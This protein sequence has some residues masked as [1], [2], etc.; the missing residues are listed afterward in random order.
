MMSQMRVLLRVKTLK[1]KENFRAV[2]RKRQEV[3]EAAKSV[4]AANARVEASRST[5]PSRE[6]AIYDEIIG[7]VVDLSAI[8]ETKAK[9]VKLEK[10]H[11]VLV[12]ELDR[13]KHV[14]AR[15]KSELEARRADHR[16][17]VKDKDKYVILTD[18]Q[19]READ[20][21]VS[22]KEEIEVE[23]LFSVRRKVAS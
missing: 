17:S 23:D 7:Q 14:E 12:D 1:E 5:L 22:A 13:T 19:Q 2:N 8:E 9:V 4:E 10:E 20:M 3:A 6:D 18:E 15:L 16:K 11:G 21:I